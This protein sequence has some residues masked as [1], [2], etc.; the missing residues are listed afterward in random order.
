[1]TIT[2]VDSKVP[3][4][5]QIHGERWIVGVEHRRVGVELRGLLQLRHQRASFSLVPARPW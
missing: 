2:E 1:M 3:I 5:V 4:R